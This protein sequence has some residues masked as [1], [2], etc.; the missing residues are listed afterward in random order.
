LQRSLHAYGWGEERV[1]I[2][3]AG[4]VGR[5]IWQKIRETPSL[6][7]RVVGFVDDDPQ[8][9]AVQSSPVLG[10]IESLFDLIKAEDVNEVIIALPETPHQEIATR[11][12][13]STR[14]VEKE[15]KRALEHCGQRLERKIV[16]RFG[17]RPEEES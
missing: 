12:G 6:G 7:Y 5:M 16:R 3:G 8:V 1:L 9:K 4:E 11:F 10:N 13:I 2:V 14:M 15:L 17:P